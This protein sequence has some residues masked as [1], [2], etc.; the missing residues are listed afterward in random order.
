MHAEMEHFCEKHVLTKN[1]TYNVLLV[2]EELLE[3]YK[4]LSKS[5]EVDVTL[6][7]SEKRNNMEI[8][9]E[10]IGEE[11]NFLDKIEPEEIGLMIIKNLTENI[12]YQRIDSRNKLSMFL[13]GN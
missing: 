3:L 5:L 6:S 7:Y 1:M 13:K 2:V 9:F 11:G 8:V 12:D 10:S 4:P